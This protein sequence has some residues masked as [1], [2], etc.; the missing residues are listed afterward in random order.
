MIAYNYNYC[1][2]RNESRGK[3]FWYLRITVIVV[4]IFLY[5]F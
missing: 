5:M 2:V 3:T 1:K 4:V